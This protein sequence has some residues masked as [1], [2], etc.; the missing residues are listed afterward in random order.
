MAA[1][2][3]FR[4]TQVASFLFYLADKLHKAVGVTGRSGSGGIG[5]LVLGSGKRVVDEVDDNGTVCSSGGHAV[6]F[7]G[8]GVGIS[9][10]GDGSWVVEDASIAIRNI[11]KGFH[12]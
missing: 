3:D 4:L 11:R 9:A 7:K 5:D 6:E 1:G 10:G 12:N 2:T 8:V